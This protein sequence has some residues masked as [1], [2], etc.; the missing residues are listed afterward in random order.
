MLEEQLKYKSLLLAYFEE[1]GIQETDNLN[2]AFGMHS[3]D[4]PKTSD[5]LCR[6]CEMY[7]QL[8]IIESKIKEYKKIIDSYTAE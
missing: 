3:D 7:L 1:K 2:L 5:F 6:E 4:W 8:D